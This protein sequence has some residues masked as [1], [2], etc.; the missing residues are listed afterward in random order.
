MQRGLSREDA[1]S[2]G[3]RGLLQST[4]RYIALG[5]EQLAA[6]DREGGLSGLEGV[7]GSIPSLSPALSLSDHPER[8]S[9][10]QGLR[11]VC[12]SVSNTTTTVPR[13][14]TSYSSIET[15]L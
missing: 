2:E 4:T 13:T 12:A 1:G 6:L 3:G 15:F 11:V 8:I 5:L 7:S 10:L 9:H 14:M